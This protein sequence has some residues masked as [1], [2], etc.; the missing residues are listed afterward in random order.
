MSSA[1][2]LAIHSFIAGYWLALGND[3][4]PIIVP[5]ALTAALLRFIC[6]M[7]RP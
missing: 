6:M 2:L 5:L 7:E 4:S 1:F 3:W